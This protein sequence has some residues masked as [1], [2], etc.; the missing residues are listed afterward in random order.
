MNINITTGIYNQTL[1]NETFPFTNTTYTFSR[2]DSV[3]HIDSILLL[4]LIIFF[5]VYSV[6]VI[7]FVVDRIKF[8]LS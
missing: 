1:T 5:V 4:T 2:S 6:F 3:I 7:D 8:L